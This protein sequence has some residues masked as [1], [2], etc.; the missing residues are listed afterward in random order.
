M[1]S[2]SSLRF[3]ACT[4]ASCG[5][6]QETTLVGRLLR[7]SSYIRFPVLPA[8]PSTNAPTLRAARRSDSPD[9]HQGRKR[10]TPHVEG[11]WAAHVYLDR[12]FRLRVFCD[13]QIDLDLRAAVEPSAGLRRVLKKAHDACT[14]ACPPKVTI[15]SLLDPRPNSSRP[16][17]PSAFSPSDSS[18]TLAQ[19][20]ENA[21]HLSLSRPLLLQT[22]QRADLRAG[23]AKVAGQVAG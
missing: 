8:K 13:F 19:T 9:L 20:S 17:T 23:V 10:T 22:N 11:Q 18:S 15:H 2:T 6:L 4:D 14:K 5:T 1:R 21:L 16:S 12:A 7:R 3:A